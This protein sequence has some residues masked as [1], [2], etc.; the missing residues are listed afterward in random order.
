MPVFVD[1]LTWVFVLKYCAKT[2][3]YWYFVV[4]VLIMFVVV[5]ITTIAVTV[6]ITVTVTVMVTTIITHVTYYYARPSLSR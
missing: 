4:T 5:T 6:T 3:R 1:I 2:V